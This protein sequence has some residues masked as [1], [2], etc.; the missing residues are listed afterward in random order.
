MFVE[1]LHLKGD[2]KCILVS[3]HLDP[4]LPKLPVLLVDASVFLNAMRTPKQAI[5]AQCL[6]LHAPWLMPELISAM[7]ANKHL[8]LDHPAEKRLIRQRLIKQRD[9]REQIQRLR[10]V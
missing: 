5:V 3:A 4:P 6:A 8:R 9:L 7:S 2:P 10:C 1:A